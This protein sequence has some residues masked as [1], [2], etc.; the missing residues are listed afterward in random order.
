MVLENILQTELDNASIRRSR[1][2]AVIAGA[3]GIGSGR[4]EIRAVERIEQLGAELRLVR[5]AYAAKALLDAA[6]NIDR[7]WGLELAFGARRI[8]ELPGLIRNERSAV[9]VLDNA[10]GP[11][12][13][14]IKARIL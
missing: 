14:V 3:I 7:P 13:A 6:C 11:R 5:F 8:P 1:D 12:P 9:E 2:T 4:T 10:I